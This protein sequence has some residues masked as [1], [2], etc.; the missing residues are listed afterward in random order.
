[1]RR[2]AIVVFPGFQVLDLVVVSVFE[3]ANQ[4]LARPAY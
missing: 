2:I 1:M 3:L 4:Q